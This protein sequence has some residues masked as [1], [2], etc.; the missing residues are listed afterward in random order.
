[1]VGSTPRLASLLFIAPSFRPTIHGALYEKYG[2]FLPADVV[3]ETFLVRDLGYNEGAARALISEYKGTLGFSGLSEPANM[4][5]AD[6]P[7]KVEVGDLVN[8]ERDGALVFANP[9][10]VA[11]VEERD[12]Q[13]WVWTEGS[14]SWTEME[15]VTLEAKADAAPKAK[16]PPPM[17]AEAKLALL[18]QPPPPEAGIQEDKFSTDEGVVTIRFPEDLSAA[19]VEELETFLQLFIKKA[20]RRAGIS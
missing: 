9:V 18:T 3:I 4:P 5:D 17:P 14:N 11:A 16:T 19:S 6:N 8:V 7:Q 10:K 1:L 20:K 2:A 13:V 15:T 12:G